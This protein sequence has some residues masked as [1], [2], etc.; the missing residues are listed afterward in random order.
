[1]GNLASAIKFNEP[2]V[3]ATELMVAGDT[4]LECEAAAGSYIKILA[5]AFALIMHDKTRRIT[6]GG[7]ANPAGGPWEWTSGKG[8]RSGG[9][10]DDDTTGPCKLSAIIAGTP[11]ANSFVFGPRRAGSPGPVTVASLPVDKTTGAVLIDP[12]DW[13]R[14]PYLTERDTERVVYYP[15]HAFTYDGIYI[16]SSWNHHKFLATKGV[17]Y[18]TR[19]APFVKT[20][21]ADVGP[22]WDSVMRLFPLTDLMAHTVAREYRAGKRFSGVKA[23]PPWN[24]KPRFNLGWYQA[25]IS[26]KWMVA[27]SET[28]F[29]FYKI[30][31]ITESGRARLI[32]MWRPSV[33]EPGLSYTPIQP[34]EYAHDDL[35]IDYIA[36]TF[37]ARAFAKVT[38]TGDHVRLSAA[39]AADTAIGG[40]MTVPDITRSVP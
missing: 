1:M 13:V 6:L 27:K 8:W 26:A 24:T 31:T 35:F 3:S 29:G 9:G 39:L 28:G 19:G 23:S 40:P 22:G 16:Y 34:A 17:M 18:N 11:D 21:R 10:G 38:A 14:I 30:H 2:L 4:R 20:V 36:L 15:S 37:L 33:K 5:I 12:V 7:S 25:I 32:G